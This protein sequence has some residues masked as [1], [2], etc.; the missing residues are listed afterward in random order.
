MTVKYNNTEWQGK[1]VILGETGLQKEQPV[2]IVIGLHGADST[3]EKMLVQGN[4]LQLKNAV[5]AYPEGPVD[6]GKGLW[7]WWKD[8]PRQKE[9]VHEFMT[10]TSKIVDTA[11]QHFA[12]KLPGTTLRICLWGFSQGAAASLVYALFGRSHPLHR[13]ASVCGFLPELPDNVSFQPSPVNIL[14]I[15]GTNDDVVPSFMADHALDEMKAKG[16]Q[17]TVRETPQGHEI[18]PENLQELTDFFNQ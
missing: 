7:S 16:H 3:P 17:L 9:S 4:R 5:M 1:K 6:A 13:V 14:G 15:Y 11:H 10:Y 8:G 2:N 18:S 12:E